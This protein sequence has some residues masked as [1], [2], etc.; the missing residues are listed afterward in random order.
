M[1]ELDSSPDTVDPRVVAGD[2][3]R[4]GIDVACEHRPTQ[5]SCRGDREH[6]CAG[7]DV[8]HVPFAPLAERGGTATF[9]LV[10][11]CLH[12]YVE[13]EQAAARGAVVPGAEGECRLDLNADLVHPHAGAMMRPVHDEAAGLD[14]REAFEALAHPIRRRQRLEHQ[15]IGRRLAGGGLDQSPH[16][17][18]VGMTAEMQC[19]RPAPVRLL[20]GGRG[21]L[22]RIEAFGQQVAD[23]LRP[24][25]V[26]RQ[27]RDHG[28]G[29]Q[30]RGVRH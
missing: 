10:A 21:D 26:G 30:G 15:R 20:E 28:R 1:D 16:R 7:T 18:F 25:A 2:G 29:G 12:Q 3:D 8:E 17:R 22:F 14:R 13:G 4:A 9:A 11:S 19:E 23:L 27:P 5:R 6:P 24:R